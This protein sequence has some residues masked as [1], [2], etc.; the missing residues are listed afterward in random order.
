MA[1]VP[2]FPLLTTSA[3]LCRI[4]QRLPFSLAFDVSYLNQ[5]L[6]LPGLLFHK[7]RGECAAAYSLKLQLAATESRRLGQHTR[8]DA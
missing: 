7:F 6:L 1:T 4:R 8:Q 5:Q 2:P 3:D